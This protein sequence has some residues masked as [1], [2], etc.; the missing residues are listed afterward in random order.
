[1]VLL[2]QEKLLNPT[3]STHRV[4][5]HAWVE[6]DSSAFNHNIAQYKSVIAPALLAPV[7][8]SNAYGHGIELMATLCEQ[9][10][11]VDIVAVVALSE[12]LLL[13]TIGI[14]KPILVLSIIDEDL[15][16][17]IVHNIDVVVFDLASAQELDRIGKAL[18]KKANVHIKVDTGLSR[19]GVHENS[20]L[21]FIET[22]HRLS[23]ITVRGIFT[24]FASSESTDQAFTNQQI[25]RFNFIVDHAA[26][27]GIHIPLRHTSCSAAT[28]ANSRSHHT[29]ARMG[30][31]LY[32]LWPSQE[33]KLMTQQMYPHFV[34]RPVLTWKTRIIL[35]K[36]IAAGSYIGY[37]QTFRAD[38]TMRIATLPVG[39]WDG[40]DR[41]FSN[42]GV[43][44]INGTLA[45]VV[46]RIA[47]NLTMVDVTH[48][49]A[50]VGDEVS[51]LGAHA[52]ITA[53][54][55]AHQ[56]DT[57]NYEIVTRINPLTPRVVQEASF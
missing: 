29:M 12:A 28:T 20:A 8:K 7:I 48:I 1:M 6:I 47:M 16:H 51:L 35:T 21:S 38:K 9:N 50:A 53:D 10:N 13:R 26:I 5:P 11:Q 57:I 45:P 43:V 46:G 52:G 30:I 4:R 44:L 2:D 3:P 24:H 25:D 56:C 14:Q 55:L 18:N 36:E 40:Y 23:H 42:K 37:D 31:G 49:P 32:G 33:N 54:D 34:L 41:R 15:E 39:Y 22:V 19:L 27:R 17:A